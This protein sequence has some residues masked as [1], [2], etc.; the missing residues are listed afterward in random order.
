[1]CIED[2]CSVGTPTDKAATADSVV[3]GGGAVQHQQQVP[4][5]N[6]RSL[7]TGRNAQPIA[8]DLR[9]VPGRREQ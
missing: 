9:D 7:S 5:V 1:M 2:R 8:E 3:I 4:L 6:H